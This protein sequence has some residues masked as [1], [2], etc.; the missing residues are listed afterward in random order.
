MG[1]VELTVADAAFG[2]LT[3]AGARAERT[4]GRVVTSDP[5]GNRMALRAA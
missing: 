1:R 4:D 5:A 3:S 2:R